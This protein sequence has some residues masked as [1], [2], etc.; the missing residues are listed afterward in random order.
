M[1]T[2]SV[3]VSA[4]L[5]GTGPAFADTIVQTQGATL[6]DVGNSFAVPAEFNP[7]DPALGTLTSVTLSLTASFSGTVEVTNTSGV[8][9]H[10]AGIIAG[11]VSV[12]TSGNLLSVEVFPS[13]EGPFHDLAPGASATDTVSG[14]DQFSSATA[15]PPASAL[16]LFIGS[17]QI[18][19]TLDATSFPIVDGQQME[20]VSETAN[21][22]AV[23]QL[24]YEYAPV[25]EPGTLA[26]GTIGFAWILA[27]R[28]WRRSLTPLRRRLPG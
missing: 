2:K 8:E 14:A 23:V 20:S 22:R 12:Y 4:L 27:M 18:F 11:T 16:E 7:F 19:L 13:A 17:E 26:L 9:D 24:T 5:L 21:A 3:L 10:A 15:T 1:R 28:G 25:P 6:L